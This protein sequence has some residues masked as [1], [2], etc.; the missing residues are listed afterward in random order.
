MPIR[1]I[2]SI[3][4]IIGISSCD[5]KKR[6]D[7]SSHL[8]SANKGKEYQKIGIKDNLPVF[9]EKLKERLNFPLSWLSG[10]YNNFEEWKI[11]ARQKVLDCLI[12]E[13]P[14]VP[15]HPVVIGEEDRGS[16]VAQRVVLNITGDSRILAYLL[17]P[18]GE[19]P[20]PAVLLLHDHGA[21][22]DIG[23]EK[24]IR[25]F[26]ENEMRL[27]SA[28]EWVNECYGGRYLG[29]E[30]AKAGYVCF[31]M[32]ALNWSDRGGGQYAGQ[33][34]IS[35][36][37]LHLGSSLA[38][39]IAY[40][41]MR[42]ADFLATRPQV[43]SSRIAAMGLSMGSFRTWQVAALSDHIKAGVAVC[44]MAT[45]KDLMAPG[46]NQIR[47]NSAYTMTHP[48]IFN[49]LDYPD[50]ASI[51][52]PKPMLFFNGLREELFTVPAVK[53]AYNKMHKVWASRDADS[54]LVTKLWDVEHV[55][56]K[57]MQ[58]EAFLWLEKY[59][60]KKNQNKPLFRILSRS[61]LN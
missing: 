35:S 61:K 39:L 2:L 49:Y 14:E 44:W 12:Y 38:G 10:N 5:S 52:C 4:V 13:P 9:Y 36:N 8:L 37:L 22:F 19:G 48:G 16:Y 20:F 24:V 46:Q 33:Q 54:C 32:D 1:F 55:F 11:I 21:R 53:K 29:D 26:D 57:E 40:E 18:K 27:K 45:V 42:A 17:I 60:L 31:A 59:L 3:I 51:A 28:Q 23:K 58:E 47:G 25:P 7:E 15:F 30:L 34:A 6:I 43:D 41:D 56:N 50:V